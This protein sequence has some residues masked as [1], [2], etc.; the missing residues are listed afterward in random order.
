[1]ALKALGVPEQDMLIVT[2]QIKGT[3][4]ARDG[5]HAVLLVFEGNDG[6]VLDIR[7]RN[8]LIMPQASAQ[9]LYMPLMAVSGRFWL[10]LHNVT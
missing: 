9:I 3:M 10:Y 4:F 1:M 7:D 6:W 2:V 5:G 8:H